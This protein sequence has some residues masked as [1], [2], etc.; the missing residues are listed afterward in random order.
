MRES[1]DD[2]EYDESVENYCAFDNVFKDYNDAINDSLSG[3]DFSQEATNYYPDNET[4]EEV[5]DTFKDSEKKVE[6]FKKT[7]VNPHRDDNSDSVFCAIL[8]AICLQLTE[9]TNACDNENELKNEINKVYLSELFLIK[10]SLKLNFDILNFEQQCHRVN[11]ILN[12]RNLFLKVYELKE[13]FQSL[14][15]QNPDKKN[16][17]REL[18]GCIT[19]KYNGFNIFWLEQSKKIMRKFVPIEIIYKPAKNCNDVISCYFSNK[20]NLAFRLTFSENGILRQGAVFQC[21][22]CSNYY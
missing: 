20:I 19:N 22:F 21:H 3:F 6:E 1:I 14:V 8:Y 10:D 5:I 16:I 4:K 12:K 11:Q 15:K 17:A 7:L 2:A 13:R 18:S 9:K